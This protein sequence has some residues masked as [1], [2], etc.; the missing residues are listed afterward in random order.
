M[1]PDQH[2]GKCLVPGIRIQDWSGPDLEFRK[3]IDPDPHTEKGIVSYQHSGKGLGLDPDPLL[4]KSL[5]PAPQS[6][7]AWFR[8]YPFRIGLEPNL[9]KA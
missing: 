6:L 4:D 9:G 5:D 1:N 7:K 3:D 8:G 2:S